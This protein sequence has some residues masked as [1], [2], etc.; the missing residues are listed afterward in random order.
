MQLLVEADLTNHDEDTDYRVSNGFLTMSEMVRL[1]RS[2]KSP[3]FAREN[4]TASVTRL[5]ALFQGPRVA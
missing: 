5:R 2:A 4:E 3:G 1:V